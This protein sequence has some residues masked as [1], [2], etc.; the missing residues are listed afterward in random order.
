MV[1]SALRRLLAGFLPGDHALSALAGPG[2]STAVLADCL[3][4]G[5][6]RGTEEGDRTLGT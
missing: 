3:S 2:P 1:S 6:G 4:A 5:V